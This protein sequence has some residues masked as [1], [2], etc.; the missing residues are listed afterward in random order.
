MLFNLGKSASL[1][2]AF[3][4]YKFGASGIKN[5]LEYEAASFAMELRIH[6]NSQSVMQF[7]GFFALGMLSQSERYKELNAADIA[8]LQS[9]FAVCGRVG[10]KGLIGVEAAYSHGA[11]A[12]PDE[13]KFTPS[14]KAASL[15]TYIN[16]GF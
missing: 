16:I 10:K 6:S 3:A 5:T 14:L 9:G 11:T 1:G 2:P 8:Y 4:F 15:S 7:E 13:N 12:K